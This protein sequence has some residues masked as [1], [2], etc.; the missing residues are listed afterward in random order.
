MAHNCV[1]KQQGHKQCAEHMLSKDGIRYRFSRQL[2]DVIDMD[3]LQQWHE[4]MLA[5]MLPR[6]SSDRLPLDDRPQSFIDRVAKGGAK[7]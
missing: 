4:L 7:T 3:Q 1:R 5:T 6:S 2:R